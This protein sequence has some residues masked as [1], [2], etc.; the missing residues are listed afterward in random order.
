MAPRFWSSFFICLSS[1]VLSYR[2]RRGYPKK[3]SALL[4]DPLGPQ[5]VTLVAHIEM[6][7]LGSHYK[8]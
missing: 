1:A 4:W 5:A 3:S 7:S 2:G 8:T 6:Q